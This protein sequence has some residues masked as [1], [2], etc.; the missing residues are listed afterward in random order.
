MAT[1][2][3]LRTATPLQQACLLQ[4][5]LRLEC[6]LLAILRLPKVRRP[7][8][9]LQWANLHQAATRLCRCSS[10]AFRQWEVRHHQATRHR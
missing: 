2:C 7:L 3:L 10:L 9:T 1:G 5:I 6:L 4:A 8:G